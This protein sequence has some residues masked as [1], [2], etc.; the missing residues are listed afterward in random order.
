MLFLNGSPSLQIKLAAAFTPQQ[1]TWG[2][3]VKSRTV[4]WSTVLSKRDGLFFKP[5]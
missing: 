3:S 1:K 2:E 5:I 4:A